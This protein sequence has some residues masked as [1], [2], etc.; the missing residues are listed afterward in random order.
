MAS[1]HAWKRLTDAKFWLA[2]ARKAVTSLPLVMS[3][4]RSNR[5]GGNR[6]PRSKILRGKDSFDTIF[7]N[8]I[9]IAGTYTDL[10]YCVYD[11]PTKGHA[12]GFV[13][14]RKLG[15]AVKRNFSKRRLREAFRLQQHILEPVLNSQEIR[16]HIVFIPKKADTSFRLIFDEMTHQLTKLAGHLAKKGEKQ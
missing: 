8:G 11:D 14:G 4:D 5:S 7:K 1:A 10:R 12:T 9:R 2:V 16:L 3:E 6:L 15:N 13:A